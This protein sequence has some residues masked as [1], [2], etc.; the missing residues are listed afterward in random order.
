LSVPNNPSQV[1]FEVVAVMAVMN[2]VFRYVCWKFLPDY[3][4]SLRSFSFLIC[5]S[6]KTFAALSNTQP[7]AGGVLIPT[8]YVTLEGRFLPA[9]V[10]ANM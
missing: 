3:T 1:W 6:S 7:S 2:A 4:A 8:V 10:T 9:V 5:Q